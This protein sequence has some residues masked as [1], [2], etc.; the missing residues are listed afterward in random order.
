MKETLA[1]NV[2]SIFNQRTD[3]T[4]AEQYFQVISII[5]NLTN[6]LIIYILQLIISFSRR[7]EYQVRTLGIQNFIFPM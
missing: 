7:N 4:S 5:V 3:A 1:Q 6:V 2:D